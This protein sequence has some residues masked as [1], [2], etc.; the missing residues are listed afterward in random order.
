M[1]TV[2]RFCGVLMLAAL[3][4]VSFA[5]RPVFADEAL[6]EFSKQDLKDL[7]VGL[8]AAYDDR[9][10]LLNVI[11]QQAQVIEDQKK[12]IDHMEQSVGKCA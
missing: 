1:N 6:P 11:L 3:M 2:T 9:L 7:L 4:M 8:K 5:P 10:N 12:Q